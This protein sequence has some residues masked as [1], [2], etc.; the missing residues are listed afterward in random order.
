MLK[1]ILSKT[2]TKGLYSSLKNLK[3]EFNIFL[4]H[5]KG[6]LRAYRLRSGKDLKL[7]LGCGHNIKKGFINVDIDKSADL[8]LDLRE[9]FPFLTGSCSL[10]YSEHFLEHLDYP[11]QAIFFLKECYRI[12]K[13]GGIFSAGVPD[14]EWPVRAYAEGRDRDYFRYAEKKQHPEWCVTKMEHLNYHFRQ[15][16]QHRFAYDFETMKYA[17]SLVG[18][19]EVKRRDFN[20]ALDS[21]EERKTGTL[22]IEASKPNPASGEKAS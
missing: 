20:P 6:L 2:V 22:Y 13:P 5:R 15:G 11:G 4:L 16:S 9:R 21:D 19:R 3:A 18:F 1:K 17:L 12:L 10:I 8:T 7:H 14:T